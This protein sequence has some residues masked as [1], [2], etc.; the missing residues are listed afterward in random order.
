MKNKEKVIYSI[1]VQDAQ[2]VAKQELGKKL[3]KEELKIIEEN[4]GENIQWYDIIA[5][6]IN[7]KIAKTRKAKITQQ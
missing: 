3:N 1:N 6:L 5:T 2:A 4:I 7:E